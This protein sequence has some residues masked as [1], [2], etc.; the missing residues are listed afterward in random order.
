MWI[1]EG[2][3]KP[4]KNQ[5]GLAAAMGLDPSGVNRLLTGQRQLKAHEVPIV[6]AYLEEPP[7]QIIAPVLPSRTGQT[8]ADLLP[9]LGM[10]EGGPDGW[11]L[12]NGE[13]IQYVPRPANLIGVPGAYAVYITGSSMS[14][15]YEAGEIVHV[16]PAKPTQPGAYVLVQRKPAQDGDPP[17]AII[18]RLVKRSGDKVTLEQFN[19]E[20]QFTIPANSIHTMHRV[21]GA[22]EG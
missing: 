4:G 21:V 19:P 10:A 13:V 22:S 14:P 17:L 9:V 2:L 20:K 7:P 18:K 8:G 5:R 3:K 11:N 16:H 15:R 1:K 6:Q 12:W